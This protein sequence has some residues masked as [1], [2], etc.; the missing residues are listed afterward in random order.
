MRKESEN[1]GAL[2]SATGAGAEFHSALE[3]IDHNLQRESR[4]KAFCDTLVE[5]DPDDRLPFLEAAHE[6]LRA[7]WPGV[8]FGGVMAEAAFWADTA[9]PAERK[10]YALAAFNRMPPR[11]QAAFL[12]YVQMRGAA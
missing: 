10:A 8:P 5:C 9:S 2:A 3:R 6:V 1:P 7:G 11:D 4:A 12:E